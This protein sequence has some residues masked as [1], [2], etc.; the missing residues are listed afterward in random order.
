MESTPADKSRENSTKNLDVSNA[1]D[2][3]NA[4]QTESRDVS[5]VTSSDFP[6]MPELDL[7]SLVIDVPR[8]YL[9]KTPLH[10][11]IMNLKYVHLNDYRSDLSDIYLDTEV[12]NTEVKEVMKTHW[13][14]LL[15]NDKGRPLII[16]IVKDMH[17][18]FRYHLCNLLSVKKEDLVAFDHYSEVVTV[19]QPLTG[20]EHE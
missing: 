4:I 13:G 16:R 20:A 9:V 12:L 11:N 15:K 8:K 5:S 3:D 19:H 1:D 6:E 14:L 18:K 17:P 2:S 7:T 10:R